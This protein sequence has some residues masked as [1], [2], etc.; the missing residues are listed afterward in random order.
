MSTTVPKTVL[1]HSPGR[2]FVHTASVESGNEE[3]PY[4]RL[5][6]LGIVAVEGQRGCFGNSLLTRSRTEPRAHGTRS[7]P[8]T[9]SVASSPGDVSHP[10]SLTTPSSTWQ[11]SR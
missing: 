4:E 9:D 5:P 3:L 11:S 1:G 7:A 10:I 8:G 2:D 6:Q